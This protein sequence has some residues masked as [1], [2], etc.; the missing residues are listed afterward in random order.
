MVSGGL[1]ALALLLLAAAAAKLTRPAEAVDALRQA[2]L[3]A[4]APLVRLLAL[5]EIAVA[6]LVVIVGGVGPALALA[7]LHLGFAGF[8]VR[9]RASVG[10]GASCGCFGGSEA[11]ADRLH[12]VVNLAAAAVAALGAATGAAALPAALGDQ[13]APGAAAY[14][15]LVAVAAQA[16]MLT[17]T[18]LPRLLA[19]N[20]LVA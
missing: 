3:P 19:A 13:P 1:H 9:L 4:S 16:T 14:L 18:A 7:G 17:L 5:S 2:R 20:R 15:V 8:I 6:G 12:V 10:A 11:P